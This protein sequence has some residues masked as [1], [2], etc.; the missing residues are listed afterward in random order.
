MMKSASIAKK[1]WLATAVLVLLTLGMSTLTQLWLLERTYYQQQLDRI[2]G[3]AEEAA[4]EVAKNSSTQSVQLNL[5]RFSEGFQSTAFWL[6]REGQVLQST[7]GNAWGRGLMHHMGG[8]MGNGNLSQLLSKVDMQGIL[9]GRKVVYQGHHPMFNMDVLT[10]GVPV[11]TDQKVSGAIVVITPLQPLDANLRSLQGVS[12]YS[13]LFGLLMATGFSWLLSKALSR[14]LIQMQHIARSMTQGDFSRRIQLDRADEIGLL[15]QSLNTLSSELE[16]KINQLQ[17]IDETRRD[18]VAS[19][20]HEL[21]TPLTIIQGNTEAI[22]DGVV[23]EPH[24]R[25]QYLSDILEETM[26]LKRL[27]NELLD[28]RKVE[29]GQTLLNTQWLDVSEVFIRVQQRVEKLAKDKDVRIT[30]DIPDKAVMVTLDP[31]RLGQILINL[32]DNAIRYSPKGEEVTIKLVEEQNQIVAEVS[33]RGQGIP[34]EEH[35]LIWDKFYKVDKSRSRT[36]GG[37][38]LGL[39]IAK[40]LIELHNGSISV[41]SV[42]GNGT[43]FRF[44]IPKDSH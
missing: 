26:H 28:L 41:V 4:Q 32:I 6:N 16:E 3:G 2:Q 38:G 7:R 15:A 21:R 37:T 27:A 20:S 44:A 36:I 33:D 10:V 12:L 40:N 29:T 35:D 34:P 5:S 14:P 18:F 19:I 23:Q 9:S 13:L 22:L 42:P 8:S 1:I 25:Y 43:T 39:A 24:K 30:L 31:H 11:W 17:R